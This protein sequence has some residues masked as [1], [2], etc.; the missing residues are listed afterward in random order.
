MCR[1]H[2][3][4]DISSI[5]DIPQE[6]YVQKVCLLLAGRKTFPSQNSNQI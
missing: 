1:T 3:P 6:N 4:N 5:F 2:I